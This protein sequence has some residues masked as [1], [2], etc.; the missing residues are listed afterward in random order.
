MCA[1]LCKSYRDRGIRLKWE[2]LST[3][4]V[5][6]KALRM[7]MLY[8]QDTKR[9]S[10][11]TFKKRGDNGLFITLDPKLSLQRFRWLNNFGDLK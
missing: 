5:M 6:I 4:G 11:N 10:I 3:Y 8:D 1:N 9:Y 2:R 7:A